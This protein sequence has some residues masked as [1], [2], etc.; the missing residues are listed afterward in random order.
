MIRERS[1]FWAQKL[2]LDHALEQ[3]IHTYSKGMLQR[4]GFI[5]SL[6]HGPKLV[7]LDEPLSGLDPRGRHEFKQII[8]DVHDVEGTTIFFSSHILSDVQEICS[9]LV[10]IDKGS[11]YYQ[12]PLEGLM[13]SEQGKS[14]EEIIYGARSK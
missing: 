4:L 1:L 14:L 12:G 6:L 3:K 5:C 9:D 2:S 13:A 8:K 11:L 10:V 7:I